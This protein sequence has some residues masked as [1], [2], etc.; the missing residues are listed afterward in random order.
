M[1]AFEIDVPLRLVPG[2][3]SL[4]RE[5]QVPP[6]GRNVRFGMHGDV[7]AHYKAQPADPQPSTLDYLTATIGGCLIGTFHQMFG[8][9]T[10]TAAQGDEHPLAQVGVVL[11]D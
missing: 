11:I 5:A 9:G 4:D 10:I 2:S 6:D 3:K 8:P 1:S 7:A